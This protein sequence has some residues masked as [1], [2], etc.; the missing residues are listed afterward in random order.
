MRSLIILLLLIQTNVAWCIDW[1][2][3]FGGSR[4]IVGITSKNISLTIQ[5]PEDAFTDYGVMTHADFSISPL[6]TFYTPDVYMNAHSRWGWFMEFGWR[7]Y[8][9]DHQEYP[10]QPDIEPVDLGT[11]VSGNFFHA[12]PMFFYNWGDRYIDEQGGRSFKVGM[13]LGLGYLSA[14]GDVI[15]TE[16]TQETH[17]FNIRGPGASV[18]VM[19]DY[20]HDNWYWRAIGGGPILQRGLYEYSL[21]DFSMDMGYIHTF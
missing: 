21:F 10:Q 4:L 16:T 2:E 1:R 3:A 7:H 12:T 20:R 14:S 5:D 6:L 9:V 19:M 18:V 8:L 13:G 17:N 11:R 15:F